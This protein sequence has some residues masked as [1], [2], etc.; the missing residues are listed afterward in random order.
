M[1]KGRGHFFFFF[2]FSE[3]EL[4]L[5]LELSPEKEII[6]MY[7][8]AL[9]FFLETKEKNTYLPHKLKSFN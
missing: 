4:D 5:P 2:F 3:T 8:P 1:G 7:F 9:F 6:L